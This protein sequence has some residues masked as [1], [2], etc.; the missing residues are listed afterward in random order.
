MYPTFFLLSLPVLSM[1]VFPAVAQ[2]SEPHTEVE[3]SDV[4][5]ATRSD[6]LLNQISSYEEAIANLDETNR[7]SA[8]ELFL[9]LART[10]LAAGGPEEARAAYAEAL[11]ALRVAEGLASERQLQ[12]LP[13]LNDVLLQLEQWEEL[14]KNLPP[15]NGHLAPSLSVR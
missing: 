5:D 13:Q 7:D 15:G 14:D 11:Q 9:S 8:A 2:V 4:S 1:V 6:D 10:Q 3:Y 12:V